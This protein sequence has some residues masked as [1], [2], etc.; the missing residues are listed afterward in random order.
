MRIANEDS[1][2]GQNEVIHGRQRRASRRLADNLINLLQVVRKTASDTAD[3]SISV[4]LADHHCADHCVILTQ[5]RLGDIDRHATA[6]HELMVRFPDL[7]VA[8]VI[9][10]IDNL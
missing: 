4:P 7:V 2:I 3:H 1:P 9:I 8:I 6:L 10:W 5:A